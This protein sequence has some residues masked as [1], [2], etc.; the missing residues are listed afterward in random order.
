MKVLLVLLNL[1]LIAIIVWQ[2]KDRFISDKP[3]SKGAYPDKS[4]SLDKSLSKDIKALQSELKRLREDI[5]RVQKNQ[6]NVVPKIQDYL[7]ELY[8]TTNDLKKK[9]ASLE[10]ITAKLKAQ[11]SEA[12]KESVPT[13]VKEIPVR[14]VIETKEPE[15]IFLKN[16]R[17]G[18]LSEC[19]ESDAQFKITNQSGSI[20]S[21]AFC[22]NVATAVAT[23]DATF[24]DICELIGW[25]NNV[26]SLKTIEEG[27]IKVYSEGKWSV[28]KPAKIKC[29]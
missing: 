17:D 25:N 21:F 10:K 26:R 11:Q 3:S 7:K 20:A 18:I 29:D 2:N 16:F 14:L 19:R 28:V 6:Q 27:Q 24:T 12:V 23:K 4:A 13:P 8:S 9:V 22:G 15:V 5:N 1:A